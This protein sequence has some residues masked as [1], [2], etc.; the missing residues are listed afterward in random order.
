MLLDTPL[1]QH[2]TIVLIV[3]HS[4]N[5]SSNTILT[6]SCY[7]IVWKAVVS[8]CSRIPAGFLLVSQDTWIFLSEKQS[9]PPE[10]PVFKPLDNGHLFSSAY[11][12][13]NLC[14]KF[15]QQ[16]PILNW[17]RVN[18]S[19]SQAGWRFKAQSAGHRLIF[20]N[21]LSAAFPKVN[22]WQSILATFNFHWCTK[23]FEVLVRL[24]VD[25]V[26]VSY[27]Y[28][29]LLYYRL[30]VRLLSLSIFL[31]IHLSWFVLQREEVMTGEREVI[32]SRNSH[33]DSWHV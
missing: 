4:S 31:V 17:S 9:I 10:L 6:L 24:L 19:S 1:W 16:S 13:R 18:I 33:W 25:A 23:G 26:L 3:H 2:S 22:L 30:V 11:L 15:L 7:Y 14:Y 8:S 28:I 5:I 20:N 27:L 29:V 21:L 12:L 32:F